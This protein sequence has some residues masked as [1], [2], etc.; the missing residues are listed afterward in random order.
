MNCAYCNH[1]VEE[2]SKVAETPCCDLKYHSTCF[3][4]AVAIRMYNNSNY[5]CL[6]GAHIYQFPM[7]HDTS[8]DVMEATTE[9]TAESLKEKSGVKEE[10]K[11]IKQKKTREATAYKEFKRKVN[12]EYEKCKESIKPHL[13]AIQNEKATAIHTLKQMPEYRAYCN[14]KS[15]ITYSYNEFM[16]KH[17]VGRRVMRYVTGQRKCYW[18]WRGPLQEIRR[19]FRYFSPRT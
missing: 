9:A 11:N 8:S 17:E 13:L 15:A 3:I 19:K 18:R 5:V 12:E 4:A 10:L 16:K 7:Y 14:A 6:C 1:T 2:G